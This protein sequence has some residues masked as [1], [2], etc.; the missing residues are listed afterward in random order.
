MR[1]LEGEIETGL[2]RAPPVPVRVL[3][4]LHRQF[5]SV[6][7]PT[8]T[9]VLTGPAG[10]IWVRRFDTHSSW[11]GHARTWERLAANET[12][13]SA[14][15]LPEGF[16]PRRVVGNLL[17]GIATDPLGVERVEVYPLDNNARNQ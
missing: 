12:A 2:F 17:F 1:R 13:L 4:P 8:F 15:Q 6:L 5:F 7:R 3:E 11:E 16:R 14:L 9:G 10:E